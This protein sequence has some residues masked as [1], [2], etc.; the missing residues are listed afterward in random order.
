MKLDWAEIGYDGRATVAEALVSLRA[1][2]R[3][4]S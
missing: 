4:V 3:S 1:V 2:L